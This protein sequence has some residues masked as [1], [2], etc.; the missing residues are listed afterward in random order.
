LYPAG[1][2]DV[3]TA[4][5]AAQALAPFAGQA[6]TVLLAI[7]LIGA[8]FLVVPVLTTAAAYALSEAF[9]WDYG[10]N[11]K[12]AQAPHF[13]LTITIATLVAMEMNFVDINPVA[14]LFWTSVVYGFLAPPLL[15]ILILVSS[16]RVIMGNRTNGRAINFLGW[17]SVAANLAAVVGLIWVSI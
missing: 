9:G 3:Q 7:G 13:Y 12:P 14:A 10:L 8:G 11:R 6:A 16:N 15:T 5:Q 2:R 17:L 1:E 4:E